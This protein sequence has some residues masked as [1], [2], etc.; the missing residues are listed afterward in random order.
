[1]GLSYSHVLALKSF[2]PT[3]LL[4]PDIL[5]F[6]F[7]I[8]AKK[9]LVNN[10]ILEKDDLFQQFFTYC[11]K[12]L[13]LKNLRNSRPQLEK[14]FEQ[15]LKTLHSIPMLNNQPDFITEIKWDKISDFSKL[16]KHISGADERKIRWTIFYLLS[17]KGK[18]IELV[19]IQK[20][21]KIFHIPNQE[22]TIRKIF[23]RKLNG[24]SASF[25]GSTII[26]ESKDDKILAQYLIDDLE[27][28]SRRS[29]MEIDWEIL[30]LLDQGSYS[31]KEL[32]VILDSSKAMISKAMTR[33]VK[34]NEIKPSSPGTRG[35][36]FFTTNCD[37]C[38]FGL[39]RS[40]CRKESLSFI[41]SALKKDFDVSLQEQDF[42]ELE[43]QGLLNIRAVLLERRQEKPR[44]ERMIDET[45]TK[46]FSKIN[47]QKSKISG[48]KKEEILRVLSRFPTLYQHGFA[49]GL[50]EGEALAA[51]L[52]ANA[53]T[54]SGQ[55]KQDL[56]KLRKFIF[57]EIRKL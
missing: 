37:N 21:L 52:I 23:R 39:E 26:I 41:T 5:F 33:L 29:P 19:D 22:K 35:S 54:K 47:A 46:I 49:Q 8:D 18:H 56:E 7:I 44:L 28:T 3:I 42:E 43:N 25:D 9:K 20:Q 14:T 15:L 32:S 57:E 10:P 53:L 16:L 55:N 30:E 4:E 36:H 11:T 50:K 1:M 12:D 48:G 17:K 40:E 51:T 13:G 31:N 6:Q 2:A 24:I 27:Y 38:P 34:N 45:L